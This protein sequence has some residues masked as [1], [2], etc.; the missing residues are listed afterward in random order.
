MG[1]TCSLLLL[2]L[3][4]TFTLFTTLTAQPTA[5]EQFSVTAESACLS[6][7]SLS[8]LCHAGDCNTL[9]IS[10]AVPVA[11][12]Q[13]ALQHSIALSVQ[14]SLTARTE[15]HTSSSHASSSQSFSRTISYNASSER[16]E[17]AF[18]GLLPTTHY[19]VSVSVLNVQPPCSSSVHDVAI[20]SRDML[21]QH[22]PAVFH[23]SEGR[24]FPVTGEHSRNIVATFVTGQQITQFAQ[25]W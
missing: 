8:Q 19:A 2:L 14:F 16:A 20:E 3:S 23:T 11:Y 18:T 12:R 5:T 7:V 13:A 4:L 9:A 25:G 1:H 22:S 17:A 6:D 24:T 15:T 10:A 21:L